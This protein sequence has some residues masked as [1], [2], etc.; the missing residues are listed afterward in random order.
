MIYGVGFIGDI[1]KNIDINA[2]DY[3]H[4]M[5]RRCYDETR[6]KVDEGRNLAYQGCKVCDEWLNFSNFYK[7]Y[8]DNYYEIDNEIMCLDKD[9]LIKGNKIYSPQTCIFAPQKINTLFCN[10]KKIR[11]NLP[12]GVTYDKRYNSYVARCNN[13]NKKT[14]YLGSRKTIEEAFMLY[15]IFK[16]KIIKD[17]ADRYKDLIPIELYNA[18]YKYEIEITD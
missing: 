13:G 6:I 18:M 11:G 14:I 8:K 17:F 4:S 15:K 10:S 5:L 16:E 3:W 2:Y 12:L 1:D 9:I 7:W